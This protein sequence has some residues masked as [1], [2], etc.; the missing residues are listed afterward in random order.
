MKAPALELA[1]RRRRRRPMAAYTAVEVLMSLAILAVGAIGIIATDKVTVAANQHAKNLAIATHVAESWIGMLNAEAALWEGSEVL[2]TEARHP[3]LFQGRDTDAW[4]RPNYV[5]RLDFGPAFDALGNPMASSTD[6]SFC[7]DLRLAPLTRGDAAGRML[8]A[9]VRVMWLRPQPIVSAADPT[10][11]SACAL[12]A[13]Q[14]SAAGASR[15][16]QFVFMASALRQ[17]GE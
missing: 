9:E 7:V 8:R 15:L 5:Q 4:F 10:L 17:G 6:A 13:V 12:N 16:A 14:A 3:W 11:S 1:A 2:L